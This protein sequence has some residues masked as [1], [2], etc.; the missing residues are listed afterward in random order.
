M[1]SIPK[2]SKISLKKK[3]RSTGGGGRRRR[4]NVISR[5]RS[6]HAQSCRAAQGAAAGVP[7]VGINGGATAAATK[8]SEKLVAL[9]NLI[10]THHHHHHHE[11]GEVVVKADQLFQETA[12]YIVRLRTQVHILQSLIEFYGSSERDVNDVVL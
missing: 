2:N 3:P 12:D 6:L 9:K 8:V 10:P 5:R 11:G 4:S 1:S 7:N